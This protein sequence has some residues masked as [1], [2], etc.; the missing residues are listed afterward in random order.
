MGD[1]LK[2]SENDR[3]CWLDLR[4]FIDT[5]AHVINEHTSILRTYRMFRTLGLRHLCVINKHNHL[6]GIVTRADLASVHINDD[7]NTN[8][9]DRSYSSASSSMAS[10]SHHMSMSMDKSS[11]H[12]GISL[13]SSGAD[14]KAPQETDRKNP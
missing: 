3:L 8:V 10:S 4:P 6:L 12:S 13:S 5:T 11:V 2:I 7:A 9:M 1:T 14:R